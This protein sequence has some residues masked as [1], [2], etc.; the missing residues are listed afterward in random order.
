MPVSA[1]VLRQI[2]SHS[3]GPVTPAAND[4]HKTLSFV[5]CAGRKDGEGLQF[6]F[7]LTFFWEI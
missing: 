2:L 5:A 4:D 1:E 3:W 6:W 7:H